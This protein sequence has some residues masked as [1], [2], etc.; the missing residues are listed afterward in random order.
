MIKQ[1]KNLHTLAD[2]VSHIE[3]QTN[4]PNFLNYIKNGHW[5]H[6]SSKEF[7][8]KLYNLTQNLQKLGVKKLDNVEIFADS[9]PHWVMADLACQLL[10]A[11]TV[12][13]FT[14][15]SK[16]NLEY[17]LT[18]TQIKYA[19]VIGASKWK[20]AKPY[21]EKFSFV[22][23][24]ELRTSYEKAINLSELFENNKHVVGNL[25]FNKFSKNVA[26]HDLASVI[27]TSGSTGGP[28]G[29]CLTHGNLIAQIKDTNKSFPISDQDV[30][31]SYL[32]LAHIFERMVMYFYLLN[33]ASIYFV[34]EVQ[35]VPELLKEVRPTIMT[36][37][38]RLLEKIYR[39]I[40]MKLEKANLG[41]KVLFKVAI[42]YALYMPTKLKKVFLFQ[43]IYHK[44]IYQKIL[45]IFG[46]RI[47]IM[48]SGGAPLSKQIYQF[49]W[50]MGLK[51]YQGYG[52]TETSPCLSTNCPDKSRLYSVGQKFSSV[53]IKIAKNGEIFAK[54]PNIMLG[55][56]NDPVNTNKIMIKG[57][58]KTGDLGYFDKD[59]Y[60]YINGRIKDLQKT[61]TG[62]YVAVIKLEEALKKIAFISDVIIIADQQK[63]V[64]ALLF[65]D[66]DSLTEH[67][68]TIE[69]LE[70]NV[71]LELQKIN[72]SF[73]DWEQIKKFHIACN[74]PSIKNGQLTPSLKLRKHIIM[75]DY[76]E[77]I[78]KFYK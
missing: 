34:D 54:G 48:I 28:K 67:N 2:L 76:K 75:K 71:F 59:G 78:N 26:K 53:K 3:K 42:L 24:H 60:L 47:R 12:P 22:F 77:I 31:L 51:L 66:M 58:L 27:Y 55:Y 7:C 21:I 11:V 17:Q 15:I 16:D 9:S 13:I 1:F 25:N 37:V 30:I 18:N 50:A 29:V 73:N 72:K 41:K 49:F 56:Y 36:T 46:G 8:L 39:G 65:P 32:P 44:L 69:K 40:E 52:L 74:M 20:V 63:F 43:Q 61:S 33:N 23:T 19:F 10:G 14:N 68:V 70:Q 38:P 57:W 35:N 4:N 45:N 5:I 62:K 64:S 6:I